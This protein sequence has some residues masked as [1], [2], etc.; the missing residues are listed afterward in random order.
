MTK[1]FKISLP[2]EKRIILHL[3]EYIKLRNTIEGSDAITQQ[4]IAKATGIRI[5]HVSRSVKRIKTDGY[6]FVRSTYIKD[7]NR[8]KKAYFLTKEGIKY[9]REI[10]SWFDK[11]SI[12]IRTL[13]NEIREIKFYEIDKFINFRIKPL[14]VFKF[15]TDSNDCVLDLKKII[16][17]RNNIDINN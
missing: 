11:K 5:E 6:V 7:Q 12:L 10:Q 4:G 9:A 2:V 17:N 14:E 1:K 15:T 3:L 13:D 16:R 8:H